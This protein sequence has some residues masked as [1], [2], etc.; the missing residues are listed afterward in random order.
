[1][2]DPELVA[3]TVASVLRLRQ[4][5]GRSL[6]ETLLGVLRD[7]HLLLLLDN[8]EHLLNACAAL[9]EAILR[10]C[11]RITI[12]AT[13]REP[14]GVGGERVYRIPSLL[15]P[16]TSETTGSEG[17]RGYDAVRL[18]VERAI[19]HQ[20]YFALDDTN[21]KAV[22]SI[23]RRL[24]GMPLAIEL[25][26]ARL[27]T[28]S[29][30]DID[31]RLGDRFRLLTGGSR[32]ALPRQ[33]T[34][35][36]LIDWSYDLLNPVERAAFA[37]LSVFAGG[38]SLQAAEVVCA[39]DDLETDNVLDALGS[40]VDKSLVQTELVGRTVRYRFLETIREY[41][42]DQLL[43]RGAT[44]VDEARG[45]HAREFLSLAETGAP[46][47]AGADYGVWLTRLEQEHDNIRAA[48]AHL[49]SDEATADEALR[50]GIAL[51]EFW[52][53][54]AYFEEGVE[55]LEESLGNP[56]APQSPALRAA[57]LTAAGKL[58]YDRGDYAAGRD[59]LE[60]GLAT[61]RRLGDLALAAD[62][63]EG[64]G[65]LEFRQGD[66][67][68]ARVRADEAV[69]L[70]RDAD[71]S[72]LI[73]HA[74]NL[75]GTVLDEIG[76]RDGARADLTEALARF[77]TAGDRRHRGTVLNNLAILDLNEGNLSAARAHLDDALVS[78]RGSG[79]VGEQLNLYCNLGWVT[80]LQ[81]DPFLSH[82]HFKDTLASARRSGSRTLV[83][84]AILGSALC[85]SAMGEEHRAAVLHG[86]AYHLLH[87]L[88]ES[89]EALEAD[90]CQ[91]D[92]SKLRQT[93]GT[94]AFE[95]ALRSGADLESEDAIVLALGIP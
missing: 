43:L 24:D 2:A 9:T 50:I 3:A 66:H 13:S 26:A 91:R 83:A 73:A 59:R 40:L 22:A 30:F 93:M 85:A 36:A 63:L 79:D 12:L 61:A 45:R 90:L 53:Y 8:C 46:H 88:G 65:W 44:E 57:A 56:D 67:T 11:S 34:L 4:E 49:L 76:D 23:C 41:A 58:H 80:L 94:N 86:A 16:P 21:F 18:F 92:Q 62:S 17:V 27:S 87:G 5:P 84:Y 7:E 78:A 29:V 1:L 52:F 89:L 10:S 47:M 19:E 77:Q 54:R 55:T 72:R 6:L 60:E 74:L 31:D 69:S 32:T 38:W 20:P 28:L 75:R 70:A 68:A 15:V 33:R 37:R 42:A 81:G 39:A 64:L 95:S 35:R 25:A 71:H 48:I 14:L 51:Y 82:Q